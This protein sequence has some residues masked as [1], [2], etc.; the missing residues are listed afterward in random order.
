MAGALPASALL[1]FSAVRL[2]NLGQTDVTPCLPL[3]CV[4]LPAP[5]PGADAGLSDANAADVS[6]P[7]LAQV[8]ALLAKTDVSH[9]CVPASRRSGARGGGIAHNPRALTA[10]ARGAAFPTDRCRWTCRVAAARCVTRC[11]RAAAPRSRSK[12]RD[13]AAFGAARFR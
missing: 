5:P 12:A 7:V 13:C 4:H 9:L 3:P 2:S 6:A 8:A 1:D 11:W 10:V